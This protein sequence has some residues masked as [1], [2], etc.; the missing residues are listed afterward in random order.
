MVL[1]ISLFKQEIKP[2][3]C[4]FKKNAYILLDIGHYSYTSKNMKSMFLEG[5]E[6]SSHLV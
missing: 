6:V 2:S 5:P 3:L 4:D 1:L